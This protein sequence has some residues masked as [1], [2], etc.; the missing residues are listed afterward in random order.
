MENFELFITVIL[1]IAYSV[2]SIWVIN[3]F[4]KLSSGIIGSICLAAGGVGL[5]FAVPIVAAVILCVFYGLI[6]ILAIFLLI[7]ALGG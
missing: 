4:T 3:R 5:Y 1:M 6:A 7:C 2:F